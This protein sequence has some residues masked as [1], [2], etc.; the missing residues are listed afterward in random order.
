MSWVRDFVK[1]VL[2]LEPSVNDAAGYGGLVVFQW[3][4][5]NNLAQPIRAVKEKVRQSIHAIIDPA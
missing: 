2:L 5:F 3:E 1:A 4:T